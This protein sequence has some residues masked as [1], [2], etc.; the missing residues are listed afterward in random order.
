[1]TSYTINTDASW[2]WKFK[3]GAWAYWIKGP[4]FHAKASGMFDARIEIKHNTIAELLAFS[5]AL[6]RVNKRVPEEERKNTTLYV[7]TDCMYVIAVLEDRIISK[8]NIMLVRAVQASARGY[9][10]VARHVKAHTG[11]LG[12]PRSYVNDWCDRMVRLEMGKE[13][14]S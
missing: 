3:R 9:K 6:E 1:M 2:S 14:Y 12:E 5:K 10:I 8:K 7:N 13:L 11:D 4:D